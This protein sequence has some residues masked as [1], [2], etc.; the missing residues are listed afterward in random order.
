MSE[1]SVTDTRKP[2]LTSIV[3]PCY[4]LSDKDAELLTFLRR[5]VETIRCHTADYELILVDNGSPIGGDYMR[6]VADICVRNSSNL[7]FALAVNQGLKLAH[8]EWLVVM[9]DDVEVMPDWLETMRAAWGSRTGAVSSHLHD[10]DPEHRAGRGHYDV[11]MGHMFGALW[12]TRRK[13][14]E[15]VGYLDEEYGLGYYEDKDFWMRLL[16][17]GYVLAKA[18]WCHHIGNA[19]SGKLP[20]LREFFFKNKERFE[21]KWNKA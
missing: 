6:R 18:G 14:I 4:I 3:I 12:M 1:E 10:A 19:T 8:G 15:E 17:A 9:N 13:V 21:A 7:G 20:G 16:T 5:C 2:L 11:P